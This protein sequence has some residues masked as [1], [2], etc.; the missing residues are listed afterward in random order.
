[1]FQA[2]WVSGRIER[3]TREKFFRKRLFNWIFTVSDLGGGGGGAE[4]KFLG[5]TCVMAKKLHAGFLQ[6]IS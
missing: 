2:Q 1:M 4:L 6:N 5:T 3:E